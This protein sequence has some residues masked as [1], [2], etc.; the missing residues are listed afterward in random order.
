MAH[1]MDSEM[2]QVPK[3]QAAVCADI[4]IQ[5]QFILCSERAAINMNLSV[6]SLNFDGSTENVIT[7]WVPTRIAWA[8]L[9]LLQ[10]EVPKLCLVSIK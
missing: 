1:L 5:L 6:V 2:I 9:C 8:K 7:T 10:L 4:L 3:S